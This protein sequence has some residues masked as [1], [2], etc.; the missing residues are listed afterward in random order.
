MF[1]LLLGLIVMK[2]SS[3]RYDNDVKFCPLTPDF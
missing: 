1:S 2:Q 3:L